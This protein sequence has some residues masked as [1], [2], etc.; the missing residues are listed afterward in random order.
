MGKELANLHHQ[1]FEALSKCR[2]QE[3]KTPK[4]LHVVDPPPIGYQAQTSKHEAKVKT[5]Q[6]ID[7]MHIPQDHMCIPQGFLECENKMGVGA[8]LKLQESTHELHPT[9]LNDF[10]EF[11]ENE[12]SSFS[13]LLRHGPNADARSKEII[14]E[15][16][17]PSPFMDVVTQSPPNVKT[18]TNKKEKEVILMRIQQQGLINMVEDKKEKTTI[19]KRI[20][21]LEQIDDTRKEEDQHSIY[22][23]Q[24][25]LREVQANTTTKGMVTHL[26]QQRA[27]L[28]KTGVYNKHDRLVKGLDQKIQHFVKLGF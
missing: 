1:L 8:I 4:N 24:F 28:L 25:K 2:S 27:N 18:T 3:H 6:L 20:R 13:P 16:Q 15:A 9:K 7:L 23:D 12:C 26:M 10:Q 5:Q 19:L 22:N 21:Q 14:V 11:K 17:P